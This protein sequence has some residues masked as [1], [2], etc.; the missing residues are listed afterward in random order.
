[1][2]RDIFG[3]GGAVVQIQGDL[4]MGEDAFFWVNADNLTTR[5]KS[6][7]NLD[8]TYLN[9]TS[10]SFGP[11]LRCKPCDWMRPYIGV[12]P[13]GAWVHTEDHS[14][15]LSPSLNSFSMGIVG[16]LG[17]DFLYKERFI[18]EAFFDYSYQPLFEGLF[19]ALDDVSINMG[20]Y[21][22]GLGIGYAF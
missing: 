7:G 3:N 18:V 12:G 14:P 15:F 6:I 21:K 13:I 8:P 5:G 4:A 22:T 11:A 20:G 10:V 2:V 19:P 16:K 9:I 17:V 1:M